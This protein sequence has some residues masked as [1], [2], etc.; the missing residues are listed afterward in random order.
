MRLSN[1]MVATRQCQRKVTYSS[2]TI[3]KNRWSLL[4]TLHVSLHYMRLLLL[5]PL[6]I[7]VL[8]GFHYFYIVFATCLSPKY[9]SFSMFYTAF[10][11][12]PAVMFH[13][14]IMDKRSYTWIS[15]LWQALPSTILA[16][17]FFLL[18]LLCRFLL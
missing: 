11:Y 7:A 4:L 8:S 16:R 2:G 10:T 1:E 6:S 18:H 13:L 5:W 9:I 17:L 15:A 12:L 14:L 3:T